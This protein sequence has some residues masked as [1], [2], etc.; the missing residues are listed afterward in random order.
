MTVTGYA[1]VRASSAALVH[2]RIFLETDK[3]VQSAEGI[4]AL[5]RVGGRI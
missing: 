4:S 2:L 1:K 3:R 5:I